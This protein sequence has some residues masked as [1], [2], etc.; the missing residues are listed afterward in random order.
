MVDG[1]DSTNLCNVH[2]MVL[3]DIHI[4]PYTHNLNMRLS[5]KIKRQARRMLQHA[6]KGQAPAREA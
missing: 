5:C 1:S 2:S 4:A 6:V 3:C